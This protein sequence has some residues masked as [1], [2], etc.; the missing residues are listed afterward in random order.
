MKFKGPRAS[1][2]GQ[3]G[4][5]APRPRPQAATPADRASAK[6]ILIIFAAS[7]ALAFRRVND[8]AIIRA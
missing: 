4:R 8:F 6:K 3:A 5:A 1:L 2:A 7:V